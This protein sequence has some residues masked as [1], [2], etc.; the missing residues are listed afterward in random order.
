[1]MPVT[2]TITPTDEP[3]ELQL[4]K[5]VF[6]GYA[7]V[8]AGGLRALLGLN[9]RKVFHSV[10]V[11]EIKDKKLACEREV[12]VDPREQDYDLLQ[13]WN[14]KYEEEAKPSPEFT[15]ILVNTVVPSEKC[16]YVCSKIMDLCTQC[17]VDK[18]VVL[19]A[20]RVEV[21]LNDIHDIYENT[22]MDKP[23]TQF[24]KLPND[25]KICDPFLS[26]LIQMIQVE[27]QPTNL[28][29]IP[30]HRA[31]LGKAR[32]EDGSQQ[33][34]SKFQEV[35]NQVTKLS[36]D[37]EL[38]FNLLYKGDNSSDSEQVSMMYS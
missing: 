21:P 11:P 12:A 3:E 5:T 22:I 38:S 15:V 25:A 32:E 1:M 10:E 14:L 4:K 24:P 30:A 19:S 8:A 17:C 28:L 9:M 7:D 20:L 36:F 27:R 13:V 2:R 29:L 35:I 34:I 31:C 37:K 6:L 18:L 26:T 23:L 16:H 33:V